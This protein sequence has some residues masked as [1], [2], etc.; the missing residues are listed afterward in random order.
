MMM[1]LALIL[2]ALVGVA[3]QETSLPADHYCMNHKPRP[4]ETRA[5]ECHCDYMCTQNPD[6]TWDD[7][8]DST[9]KLFCRKNACTCWPEAPCPKKT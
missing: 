8:E 9:C 1:R 2:I 5:H 6:G 7:H 3:A 4:N